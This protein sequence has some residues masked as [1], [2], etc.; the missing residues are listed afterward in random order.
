M[1]MDS[2]N[3]GKDFVIGF[4]GIWD[5]YLDFIFEKYFFFFGNFGSGGG[6][7]IVLDM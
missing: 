1:M 5:V 4:I 2:D 7:E 3:Y 6:L